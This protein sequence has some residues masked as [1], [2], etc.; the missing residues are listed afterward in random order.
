MSVSVQMTQATLQPPLTVD[1]T[2]SA[3]PHPS[4]E[5]RRTAPSS[6]QSMEQEGEAAFIAVRDL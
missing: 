6:L 5:V 1:T 4:A 3:T 2:V